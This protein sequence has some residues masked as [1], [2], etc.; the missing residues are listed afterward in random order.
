M[1]RSEP[2]ALAR[3]LKA[4]IAPYVNDPQACLAEPIAFEVLRHATDAEAEKLLRQFETMVLLTSPV[5]LWHQAADL[6]H[7]VAGPA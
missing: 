3:A 5:D 4:F 6:G 2:G 1:D 7:P